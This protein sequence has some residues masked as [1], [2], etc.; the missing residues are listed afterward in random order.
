[1]KGKI[2]RIFSIISNKEEPLGEILQRELPDLTSE[3]QKQL[4]DFFDSYFKRKLTEAA[5]KDEK[6][7]ERI[8]KFAEMVK[9]NQNNNL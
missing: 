9:K 8:N 3:E 5:G 6:V 1:M 7:A 4:G 2:K